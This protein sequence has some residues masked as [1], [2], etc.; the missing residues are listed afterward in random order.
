[1][2]DVTTSL[3]I[4]ASNNETHDKLNINKDESIFK[5]KVKKVKLALSK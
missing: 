5:N 1:M 2:E 4:S 3:N